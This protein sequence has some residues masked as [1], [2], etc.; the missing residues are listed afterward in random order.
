MPKKRRN[1]NNS[2][3]EPRNARKAKREEAKL[4]QKAR[5]R[6]VRAAARVS[7]Q[8]KPLSLCDYWIWGYVTDLDLF[9]APVVIN[10]ARFPTGVAVWSTED[11]VKRRVQAEH[12]ISSSVPLPE[13]QKPHYYRLGEELDPEV[14][15]KAAVHMYRQA[16]QHHMGAIADVAEA[17]FRT[18]MVYIDPPSMLINDEMFVQ[19]TREDRVR[20]IDLVSDW[21]LDEIVSWRP[22]LP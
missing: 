8:V 14:F 20:R 15:G 18:G 10:P 2:S 3:S 9:I 16:L 17:E 21:N 11:A 6:F 1:P 22:D 5:K 19:M 12:M 13:G 4:E 7:V